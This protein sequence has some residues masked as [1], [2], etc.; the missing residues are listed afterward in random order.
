MS[1]I[2]GPELLDLTVG[3]VVDVA[4]KTSLPLAAGLVLSQLAGTAAAKHLR[5]VV[6]CIAVPVV[7]IATVY[8]RGEA[9]V[10]ADAPA[11]PLM[12]W[13]VGFSVGALGMLRA[14]WLL[15]RLPTSA[16]SPGLE[17]SDHVHTPITAGWLSPRIIVP[18]DFASWEPSAQQAALAHEQ[19]HIVRRDWLVHMAVWGLACVL[20]FNPLM[21]WT[22]QRLSLL[23]ECAA[24]DSVLRGGAEPA[25]Y[26]S[27]LL[28]LAQPGPRAAL[29][30]SVSPV[31]TR[32]R[33]VLDDRS[34]GGA[35]TVSGLLVA[36]LF[37]AV[38]VGVSK[39]KTWES[40]P[41]VYDCLPADGDVDLGPVPLGPEYLPYLYEGQ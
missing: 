21:W 6:A 17:R 35:S 36:T 40:P 32:I 20:W 38:G 11:W 5:V 25:A 37:L 41:V 4:W 7:A 22:R 33:A 24:D 14:L 10:W 16:L 19:A 30:F 3:L 26:A 2:V 31:G 18:R 27:Q 34:R 1:G 23:A 9:A 39:V 28:A 8:S 29:A 15:Y 12:L 13:A